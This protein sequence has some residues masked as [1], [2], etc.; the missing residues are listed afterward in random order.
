MARVEKDVNENL[1]KQSLR[2]HVDGLNRT[3]SMLKDL[4]GKLSSQEMP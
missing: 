4:Y 3:E 1:G 2:K